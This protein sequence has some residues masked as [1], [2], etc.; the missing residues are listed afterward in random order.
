MINP[1]RNNLYKNLTRDDSPASIRN[2]HRYRV[3]RNRPP[4]CVLSSHSFIM[5]NLLLFAALSVKVLS[6]ATPEPPHLNITTTL[7]G[8]GIPASIIP[9]SQGCADACEALKRIFG[10]DKVET[11]SE[12]AYSAFVGAFWSRQQREIAP[13]CVFKPEKA[14]DVSTVVL[15]ARLTQCKFA[16]KSG[17]HS[18][19][20]GGSNIQDGITIS[21]E[22][23][24]QT[25]VS[26]DKKSVSFQPGQVW[27]DVYTKLDK[28]N[29][30]IIGGRVSD[31]GVGG[32][33]LGGGISF[34][35][36]MYGLACDNVI[37]YELV[38]ASGQIINVS[39]TSY[40]DLF[41]A[42]RGGGNNFGLVT[43]FTV[44]AI[45]RASTMW[46]GSRTYASPSFPSLIKAYYNLGMSAK[47]DPKAHQILSF[48]WGGPQVGGVSQLE[49]EYA[50]PNA[51]APVLAEYNA[52]PGAF[53][54]GT[55]INT[56]A[57]LTTA[58]GGPTTTIGLRQSFW[59]WSA[60]LD[61]DLATTIKDI[62]YEELPNI[63]NVT[64]V[65]PALSF[66]VIT[67]PIIE[68]TQKNGGNPLGLDPK[69]GP[70]LLAF[71]PV[72]YSDAANDDKIYKFSATVKARSVAA[73]KAK[74][75]HNDYLYMNYGSAF[76]DPVAGYG[77]ANKARLVAVSQKYD[78]TGV[79][80]KLQPG[81][82][83]LAGAPRSGY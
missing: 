41:W 78:P 21:F 20:P 48:G 31:V 83:K 28:D 68:Q 25:V 12:S 18:A 5:K 49:L 38:T 33:T 17:G 42:L 15:I 44:N 54:D 24:N 69:N 19:V 1:R 13:K 58:L 67:E 55:K 27:Y 37:S 16:A 11:Q 60:K 79:F 7:L 75:I 73:A 3:L 52:I 43:K 76:Q 22:R 30:A 6:L 82:F 74:G 71:I 35:S 70:L 26:N 45:P 46:G 23:M 14:S 63:L 2:Q 47:K 56:L 36:S 64:N 72:S 40:P 32:L 39:K 34:F 77:S 57:N 61:A 8:N 10:D 50:D 80:E 65:L 66:Q 53:L 62:F 9:K 59:T 29:L 81:Y 4:R 51:N